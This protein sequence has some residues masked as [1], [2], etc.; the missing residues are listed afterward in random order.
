VLVSAPPEVGAALRLHAAGLGTAA[1][2]AAAAARLAALGRGESDGDLPDLPCRAS[3]YCSLGRVR[4]YHGEVDSTAGLRAALKAASF[5]REVILITIGDNGHVLGASLAASLAHLGLAHVMLFAADAAACARL[6]PA[7]E[8]LSCAWSDAEWFPTP[9]GAGTSIWMRRYIL[10]ARAAWMGYNACTMD[11]D[12]WFFDDPYSYLKA[13]PFADVAVLSMRDGWNGG[14]VN[15]GFIYAQGAG[16]GT[17]GGWLLAAGA[18]R[19]LRL[20]ENWDYFVAANEPRHD[21]GSWMQ[22]QVRG[23]G[24]A[25]HKLRVSGS[26]RPAPSLAPQLVWNDAVATA[27][28]GDAYAFFRASY[29][30]YESMGWESQREWRAEPL[31][32]Q[33]FVKQS[34]AMDV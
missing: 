29:E 16:A 17:P 4:P 13:P 31:S 3:G 24:C 7:L 8:H 32:L 14:L 25:V 12:A 33:T 18:D 10:H 22:D 5:R 9:V 27:A 20:N 34:V 19:M 23:A 21:L 30:M 28:T 2:R 26:H 1:G 6:P 11:A 15:S